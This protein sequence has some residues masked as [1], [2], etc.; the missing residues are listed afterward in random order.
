MN[1]AMSVQVCTIHIFVQKYIVYNRQVNTYLLHEQEAHT[2]HDKGI[3][4]LSVNEKHQ[5]VVQIST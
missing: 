4:L 3:C 5:Q 2:A 1:E